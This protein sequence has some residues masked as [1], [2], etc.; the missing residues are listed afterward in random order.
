MDIGV[1][2]TAKTLK[3]MG[4]NREVDLYPSLFLGASSLT[5]IEVTQMYQTLAGDGF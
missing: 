4:V 1:A 5:P 2:R 3:E